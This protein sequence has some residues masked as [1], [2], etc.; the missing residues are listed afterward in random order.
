MS[1]RTFRQRGQGYGNVAVNITAKI[2]GSVVYNGDVDTDPVPPPL[3]PD[4]TIDLGIPIFSWTNPNIRFEGVAYME[5]TVNNSVNDNCFLYL[6]DTEANYQIIFDEEIQLA[7]FKGPDFYSWVYSEILEDDQGSWM[8]SDPLT[9]VFITGVPVNSHPTRSYP[10]QYYWKIYPQQTLT[11][12]VNIS[13]GFGIPPEFDIT[14]SYDEDNAVLFNLATY[15]SL[16]ST[17]GNLPSDPVF[18]KQWGIIDFD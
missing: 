8:S 9:D 14:K 6:T 2:N 7:R 3:L 4:P 12:T 10:G 1:T 18:W 5:I 11:C 13:R 15:V 16:Q 17:T